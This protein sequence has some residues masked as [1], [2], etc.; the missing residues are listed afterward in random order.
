MRADRTR[1]RVGSWLALV[2]GIAAALAPKC[3]LC[4]AA[5]LSI[6]G[7]NVAVARFLAPLF[8]PVGLALGAFGLA[9]LVALRWARA[10]YPLTQRRDEL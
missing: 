4:L 2:A 10:P 6:V 1:A 5:Y 3:P 9:A 7:V 8:L